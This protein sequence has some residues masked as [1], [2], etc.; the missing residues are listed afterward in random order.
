MA[1]DYFTPVIQA[2]GSSIGIEGLALDEYQSCMLFVDDLTL[3]LQW[4]SESE[5]L[6]V[7]APVGMIDKDAPDTAQLIQLLEANCLGMDTGGLTLGLQPA[8]GTVVLSGQLPTHNL[9]PVVLERFIN[10]FVEMAVEW[11]DRLE[12][13]QT[14]PKTPS[15]MPAMP[16]GI[17]V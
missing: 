17:R 2:F 10:F 11:A 6:L 16:A 13:P 3:N 4:K 1:Q 8:F 7:Y 12:Q 14:G 9:E 15:E 5:A